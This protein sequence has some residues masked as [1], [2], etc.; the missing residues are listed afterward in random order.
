ML[1]SVGKGRDVC[2][3]SRYSRAFFD[4]ETACGGFTSAISEYISSPS[5]TVDHFELAQNF[6]RFSSQ[7]DEEETS[8]AE[9]SE[10]IF[11]R[12][13][14]SSV[15]LAFLGPSIVAWVTRIFF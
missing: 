7:A 13:D 9:S 14:D 15:L 12:C 3:G 10:M 5:L 8:A 4:L 11:A 6:V 1:C 2:L